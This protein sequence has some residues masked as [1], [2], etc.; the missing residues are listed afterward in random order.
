MNILLKHIIRNMRDNVGRTTLIM[1]SL[2][3]VSILV[4]I[5]SLAI[6]FIVMIV[7]AGS[8][9]ATFDYEIQS[10]TGE[11]ILSD[12]VKNVENDFEILGMPEVE[13]GYMID[14]N[15]NYISTALDGLK[16]EQ[17]INFKIINCFPRLFSTFFHKEQISQQQH[18]T[19]RQRNQRRLGKSGHD[20]GDKG[21]HSHADRI[22]QLG[23]Y[24]VHM[25]T[26][27]S[28]RRHNRC[29]GDGR[30]VVTA[31]SACHTS[32]DSYRH[33]RRM[34]SLERVYHNRDQ[35]TEG[36]PGGTCREGQ[37]AANQENDGRKQRYHTLRA[38]LNHVRHELRS[39][40]TVCHSL[41]C[42]CKG[43]NHDGRNHGLEALRDAVHALL[44]AQNFTAHIQQNRDDQGE[45]ASDSQSDRRVAVGKCGYKI[46]A[47]EEAAG[48]DHADNAA[49][50]QGKNRDQKIL[51][52]TISHI[53]QSVRVAVRPV[54]SGEQIAL[55]RVVLMHL[56]GAEVDI[57]NRNGN[58]HN[59]GQN[60]V[61]VV[62]NRADEQSQSVLA[63]YKAGYCR[64]PG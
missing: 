37:E 7:D 5:I 40:Q 38:A 56:H 61:K 42:P 19:Y 32:G 30:T 28:R 6:M 36:S 48:V 17:A 55:L 54:R 46:C 22:G 2:F 12:V 10:S 27:G 51:Y 63:L 47:V 39:T 20:I 44:E 13:Y 29:I 58:H 1:L 43:Q 4:A 9:L 64:R 59:D 15:E 26:L 16:V 50:N 11:K 45:S 31:D 34:G 21:N 49:D 53:V 33:Q 14:S 8:N 3:V 57:Q 25:V 18:D 23:R 52:G 41:Q 62:R 24:M 35:D 60:R